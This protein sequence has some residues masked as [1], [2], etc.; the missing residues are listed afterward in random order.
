MHVFLQ[1]APPFSGQQNKTPVIEAGCNEFCDEI[2]AFV[3][4]CCLNNKKKLTNTKQTCV[5]CSIVK[6]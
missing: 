3:Q 2:V 4:N 6:K 5:F 1:D